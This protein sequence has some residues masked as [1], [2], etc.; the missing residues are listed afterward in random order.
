[1]KTI[2]DF[3]ADNLLPEQ[4]IVQTKNSKIEKMSKFFNKKEYD[5]E[6]EILWQ[7]LKSMIFKQTGPAE[8]KIVKLEFNELYNIFCFKK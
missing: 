5:N 4:L 8:A 7:F 1:M 6:I 3:V 2:F